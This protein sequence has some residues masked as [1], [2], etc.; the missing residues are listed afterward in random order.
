MINKEA[1]YKAREDTKNEI[2]EKLKTCDRFG[3][4]RPQGFGKT[5][6]ITELCKELS[7]KKLIIEPTEGINE[8]IEQF[9]LTKSTDCIIYHNLLHKDF[10]P[11]ELLQYDY[12]FLDEM[13]RALAP[14]WGSVLK[15][16]LSKFK[17]KVIG[18]SA[19]PIRGDGLNS[20]QKL[21]DGE[22][23]SE[24]SLV[25]AILEGLL[26]QPTYVT[27]IYEVQEK[28]IANIVKNET[29]AKQFYDYDLNNNLEFIFK[30]YLD[31]TP[32]KCLHIIVFCHRISD[33]K[34]ARANMERWI[35]IRPVKH[36]EV[37]SDRYKEENQ[38]AIKDFESATTGLNIVYSANMLNEGIHPKKLDAV[39]FLRKTKS[40][41][42]YKQQLGRVISEYLDNSIVFD[43]VNNIYSIETG[44][45]KE[46]K[47][48]AK[49]HN[50][51]YEDIK[52]KLNEPLKI[53][54]EQKDLIEL[55]QSTHL[56]KYTEE[57]N[58][59]IKNYVFNSYKTK[60]ITQIAKELEV[61][62]NKI[63]S[64]YHKFNLKSIVRFKSISEEEQKYIINNH[65]T[66]TVAQIA[67]DL[68]RHP[69][70]VLQF[71]HRHNLDFKRKQ[72]ILTEEEQK[73]IIECYK[74]KSM[75]VKTIVEECNKKNIPITMDRVRKILY[76]NGLSKNV[77]HLTEE[78][79]KYILNNYKNMS[80]TKIGKT[81]NRSRK[82][83]TKF[84]KNN[85]LT[86]RYSHYK[87]DENQKE[88]ITKYILKNYGIK[89][90]R[91]M[92][93]ELNVCEE[94]IRKICKS[95]NLSTKIRHKVSSISNEEKQFIKNNY[96]KLSAYKISKI[97]HRSKSSVLRYVN[98]YKKEESYDRNN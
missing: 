12:I 65:K 33:I 46:F 71:M 8:Y 47:S 63:I 39:V 26:P 13:H 31:L 11:K 18:F 64:I 70:T 19:T 58:E 91:L 96:K 42:V 67:E 40:N 83:L 25:E 38:K 55:I 66:K 30:K 80:I 61:D 79:K 78:E 15:E 60:N 51:K 16:T 74:D 57:E 22:Q 85:N 10:N 4:V 87:I 34:K 76:K 23:I 88:A 89:T 69:G 14:N 20:V 6:I 77:R 2:L 68:N 27:G 84:Y 48:Y 43:L 35:D 17:G 59:Y 41:V 72:I 54:E 29:L 97:L 52:T 9:G 21:F 81:L 62:K 50:I 45:M 93:S 5:Y 86:S 44:Y 73:Y 53:Y 7:G 37:H 92:A 28:D 95:H 32:N 56:R 75:S 36:Y 49:E 24:L 98:I 94:Y 82:I 1:L 3:V 90:I